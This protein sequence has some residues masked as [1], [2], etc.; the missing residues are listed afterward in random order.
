MSLTS[1]SPRTVLRV[2]YHV[3]VRTLP[4][5][6]SRY[7][8][9]DF[10]LPQLFACLVLMCFERKDYRGVE[11]MLRDC[12]ALSEAIGLRRVPDHTTL[13][14]AARKLFGDDTT[15][16]LLHATVR[17]MMGR[18]KHVQA[19]AIDST[20][21]P[22]TC[23]S[24]Y[25]LSRKNQRQ[26]RPRDHLH[27]YGKA[28][29][30]VDTFN[31]LALGVYCSRGPRPDIDE[32]VPVV[33]RRS[34]HVVIH[35]LLADAGYDSTGNPH[36]L[37][38]DHGIH[39]TIPAKGRGKHKDAPARDPLRRRMQTHFNGKRYR[40]RAQAETVMSM[41]KRNLGDRLN[42]YT[43]AARERQMHLKVL[44]HNIMITWRYRGS[45]Q[46]RS[47]PYTGQGKGHAP[48]WQGFIHRGCEVLRM[49]QP[50]RVVGLGGC[51]GA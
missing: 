20:G 51:L 49:S 23:A 30:L 28:G 29:L 6:A 35:H 15:D 36:Y 12:P 8:R 2:A 40:H 4:A 18:R 5:Y 47:D 21:F 39:S 22:C 37:R 7:S 33:E 31:H 3:G 26:D 43:D 38:N 25:Y 17:L 45:Q 24:K 44:T 50:G 19:A 1:K 13:C 11:A 9:H 14:R 34:R 46:S 48:T 42:T 41:I 10:T 27:A 32:L 16:T